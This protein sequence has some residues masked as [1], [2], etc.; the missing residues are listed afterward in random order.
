[1]VGIAVGPI[2]RVC[3]VIEFLEK[4]TAAYPAVRFIVRPHPSLRIGELAAA[5]KVFGE[6]VDLQP[7]KVM[8]ISLFFDCI[9]L[10]VVNDSGIFFE[11]IMAEVPILRLK[12]SNFDSNI[13]GVPATFNKFY[14]AL[15]FAASNLRDIVLEQDPKTVKEHLFCNFNTKYWMKSKALKVKIS[16]GIINGEV[17]EACNQFRY[18]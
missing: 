6:S 17:D 10:L 12:F 16:G 18:N 1:M 5:L 3:S 8:S 4:A 11:S 9:D 15:D 2:D 7:P 14:D 13:Y